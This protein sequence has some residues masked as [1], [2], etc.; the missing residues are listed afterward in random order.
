MH[1]LLWVF[2]VLV[3]GLI[4]FA[5]GVIAGRYLERTTLEL[6]CDGFGLFTSN[7]CRRSR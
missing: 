6:E 3:F 1:W 7:A 4:S 2:G 5:S